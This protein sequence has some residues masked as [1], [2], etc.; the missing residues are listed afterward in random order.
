[1]TLGVFHK[2]GWL[3]IAYIS[4]VHNAGGDLAS[5]DQVAKPPRGER[6]NLVVV[7]HAPMYICTRM[8]GQAVI[9]VKKAPKGLDLLGFT[10]AQSDFDTC[11]SLQ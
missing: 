1:M 8:Y 11:Q 2:F 3:D 5:F 6:V 10:L 4:F 7:V 9:D